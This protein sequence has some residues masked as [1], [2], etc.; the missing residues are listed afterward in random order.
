MFISKKAQLSKNC[1]V[2]DLYEF[3]LMR[4][5]QKMFLLPILK[6]I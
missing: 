6:L 3:N 5:N 4:I 1:L 2:L